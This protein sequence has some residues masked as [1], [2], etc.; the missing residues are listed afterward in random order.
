MPALTNKQILLAVSGG[1]AAYKAAET[2]RRLKDAGAS[3]RVILTRGGQ[4]FITPLTMQALSGNPTHTD[5]LDPQAEAGMG[6]IQLARWA[7][8]LLVAP[9]TADCI[10]RLAH[11]QADDLLGAVWLATEA[12]R[13][14][15]PAMNHQMW[16]DAGTQEN[17]GLLASR[18]VQVWGPAAGDQACGEI[19]PGRM[20]EAT[21]LANRC[22]T[23]FES[24]VLQGV[25]LLITAGPTREAID[26][27][28][29][30][31]N[32]SSGKMGFALAEA[33][34]AAGARVTLIAGPVSL[35]TPERVQR[36]DVESAQE[37]LQAV[38]S[39]L[40]DCQLFIACAAVADYRAAATSNEKIKKTSDTMSLSLVRNPDILA[41][42]S[43]GDPRPFCVGFAAETGNLD[44]HARDKLARKKLD[45]LIANLV[46]APTGGMERDENA[47]CIYHADGRV[48]T[49][50]LQRKSALARTLI[51]QIATAFQA[52]H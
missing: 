51:E 20:L 3:V 21:E 17:V 18:G 6:H 2:V 11:G 9:A 46:G 31:S 35:A 8:L 30:I 42:V 5:L 34:V 33:A 4:E 12:P 39:R 40:N 1:I 19:G 37:M 7:D 16:L 38:Q 14:I 36:I 29:F 32:R 47:V 49:L 15:A 13:A 45:L 26:P 23:A 43:A 28:R 48:D 25:N 24:G 27:V 22:G 10:A 50:E 44:A 41:T 52:G